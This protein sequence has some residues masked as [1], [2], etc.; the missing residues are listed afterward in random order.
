LLHTIQACR[1]L[2]VLLVVLFHGSTMVAHRYGIPPFFDVFSLGFSGVYL[3]FVLS[4]FIILTAHIKDIGNPG[5]LGWYVARRLIRIYPIYWIVFLVWGGWKL[6]SV[7]PDI[8]EFARNAFLFMSNGK[9]VIPVSWTLLYEIIF[10]ALFAVLVL[11]KRIGIAVMGIWFLAILFQWGKAGPHILH[12]FNLLFVF[13][14]AA[15]ALSFRLGKLR[16]GA[17][18]I[19]AAVSLSL[20]ITLF[21]GT[22]AHYSTLPVEKSAWPEHPVTIIGFGLASALLVL[23]SA[24]ESIDRFFRERHFIGLIGNASYSIYLVHIQFEKIALNAVKSVNWVWKDEARNPMVSDL[25][26]VYVAGAAV[27]CGI[28]IHLK[29]ERPL[30]AFLRGRLNAVGRRVNAEAPA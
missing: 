9:L 28:I 21:L 19:I 17:R 22:A 27:L 23:A 24:S 7:K 30:L 5:R 1:G 6:V 13:G 25:L 14:L 20:G 26:L 3:F 8:P 18:Q 29:I 4:G 2:A 12:P 15:A 10:Y 11:N 16:A